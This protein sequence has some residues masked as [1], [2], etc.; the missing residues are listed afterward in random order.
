MSS[1]VAARASS[2][3]RGLYRGV[4]GIWEA[5]SHVEQPHTRVRSGGLGRSVQRARG[6]ARR[7]CQ[8]RAVYWSSPARGESRIVNE[9]RARDPDV[10]AS[11]A[12]A[13][14]CASD[15][16]RREPDLEAPYSA[17]CTPS[18]RC[19]HTQSSCARVPIAATT[20]PP[21]YRSAA[22]VQRAPCAS[23]ANPPAERAKQAAG[24]K[25]ESGTPRDAPAATLTESASQRLARRRAQPR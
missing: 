10:A 11:T 16:G 18:A 5:V 15:C 7:R 2:W 21:F 14:F 3:W 12:Y 22:S 20:S 24:S 8:R 23:P 4:R 6:R 25:S 9:P 17:R 13:S 19:S 1:S